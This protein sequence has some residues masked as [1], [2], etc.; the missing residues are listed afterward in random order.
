MLSPSTGS[1]AT[2]HHNNGGSS[3]INQ[4]SS[5]QQHNYKEYRMRYYKHMNYNIF[6]ADSGQ[7]T[8]QSAQPQ[9]NQVNE[10]AQKGAIMDNSGSQKVLTFQ[11]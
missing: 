11:N 7:I 10:S 5:A 3:S 2:A 9:D 8:D 1:R 6:Q 4:Q